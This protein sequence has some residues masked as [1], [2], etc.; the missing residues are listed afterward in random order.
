MNQLPDAYQ[1][2]SV[3]IKIDEVLKIANEYQDLILKQ[4]ELSREQWNSNPE[5]LWRPDAPGVAAN[6]L[7]AANEPFPGERLGT[8]IKS[9]ILEFE[10]T[11]GYAELAKAA[12]AIFNYME[13]VSDKNHWVDGIFIANN[14]SW[15]L[16]YLDGLEVNL[17][18]IKAS[19]NTCN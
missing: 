9:L 18:M 8:G 12:P 6:A 13:P 17:K 19:V 14:L 11:P 1:K 4:E 2:S 10:K 3:N 16:I 5:L 15:A 7:L